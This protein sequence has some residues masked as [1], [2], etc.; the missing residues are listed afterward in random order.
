MDEGVA[1]CIA[2]LQNRKTK[3]I[4]RN[5]WIKHVTKASNMNMGVKPYDLHTIFYSNEDKKPD[6]N[7]SVKED[8]VDGIDCCYNAYILKSYGEILFDFNTWIF[9][10]VKNI[11]SNFS[12]IFRILV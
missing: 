11:T 9:F 4:I 5:D 1:H 6:F 8:F 3:L 7:L 2:L 10:I 12:I